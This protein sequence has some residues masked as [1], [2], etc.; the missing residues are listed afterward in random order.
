VS[1]LNAINCCAGLILTRSIKSVSLKTVLFDNNWWL[2]FVKTNENAQQKE[3]QKNLLNVKDVVIGNLNSQFKSCPFAIET[4]K[5][6]M[7]TLIK[8]EIYYLLIVYRFLNKFQMKTAIY[9]V[10]MSSILVLKIWLFQFFL[11]PHLRLDQLS[12]WNPRKE[13]KMI[14]PIMYFY[15]LF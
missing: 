6:E 14:S 11:L 3:T 12:K 9:S 2:N 7:M 13:R 4:A 1:V 15:F 10:L 5:L 8:K